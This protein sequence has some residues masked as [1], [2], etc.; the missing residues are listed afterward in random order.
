MLFAHNVSA[1]PEVLDA[2]NEALRQQVLCLCYALFLIEVFHY[3]G[4]L[5]LSGA[6]VGGT[7]SVRQVSQLE[8][9]YR[10]NGA[11]TV[12][13]THAELLTAARAAAG[14]QS[15]HA[16]HGHHGRLRKGFH[17]WLRGMME[18]HG[19]ERLHQFVR[20]VEA[21]VM[22][23]KGRSTNIFAHRC[24]LFA[25]N[26]APAV[27]LLKELYELRNSAEH[28]NPFTQVLGAYPTGDHERI[29]LRRAYQAQVLASDV[30]RRIFLDPQLL[31][32]F[33][34]DA[35]ISAFW[36]TPWAQQVHA[37]GAASDLDA[38]ATSRMLV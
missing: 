17:A 24:Q 33:S 16:G 38:L 11:K 2:E 15:V 37:W 35:S 20:A 14:M 9:F 23:P 30:Y 8:R 12:R 19:E 4:G 28:H 3:D 22:P 27:S 7:V 31:A 5:I 21:V 34:A 36:A 13:L 1:T 29:A 6:N 10:P 32:H 26:T 18:S 25:G